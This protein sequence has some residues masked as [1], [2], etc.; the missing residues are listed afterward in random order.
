[1]QTLIKILVDIGSSFN[2][3]KQDET[4]EKILEIAPMT[5]DPEFSGNK[6]VYR[7]TE[8]SEKIARELGCQAEISQATNK[9]TQHIRRKMGFEKL[10]TINYK[11]VEVDGVKPLDISAMNGTT[12][13]IV[14]IKRL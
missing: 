2:V 5:V 13:A 14:F 7:M 4:L 10:S 6:L 8:E 3:F 1:V 9:I 12:S 11:D